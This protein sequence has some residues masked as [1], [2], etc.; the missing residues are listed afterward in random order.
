[1]NKLFIEGNYLIIDRDG[2]VA[3]FSIKSTDYSLAIEPDGYVIKTAGKDPITILSTDIDTW[4]DED[5]LVQFTE[6]SLIVFLRLNT[7]F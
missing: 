2:E 4:Y 1:M 3:N 6:A 5:G 7:G